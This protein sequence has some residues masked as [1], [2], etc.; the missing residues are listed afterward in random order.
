MVPKIIREVV[1]NDLC[2]GCGVCITVCPTNSISMAWNK[3]GLL[4]PIQNG[5]CE[6]EKKCIDV[7]P[8]NPTPKNILR[9]ENEI[10]SIFNENFTNEDSILG[11]YISIYSG[12]SSYFRSLSSSGGIATWVLKEI[13]LKKIADSVIVVGEDT[14]ENS[15]LFHYSKIDFPDELSQ[16]SQTKYYPITLSEVLLEI[17]KSEKKVA[18]IGIPCF[19]K[20]LRL[21]QYFYPSFG[22]KVVF[23]IGIFCGGMKSSF[24]T[25]Y[26][27][28]R[29]GVYKNEIVK[30]QYRIKDLSSTASDY[31][32]GVYNRYSKDF[33]SMKM[34]TVG[35]MWGTGMFKPNACEFCD[36]LSAELADIS[37]GDAWISPYAENGAGTNVI[38]VRTKAAEDLLL[39]GVENKEIILENLSKEQAVLSQRG[40]YNHR[41]I[42]LAHRIHLAE[43]KSKIIPPKR[44]SGNRNIDLAFRLVL[45]QRS[46]VREKSFIYWRESNRFEEFEKNM[47]FSLKWLKIFTFF[48]HLTRGQSLRIRLIRLFNSLAL[49]NK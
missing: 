31:S 47:K 17:E 5:K 9:T 32:F 12:Y 21:K 22:E 37:L 10:S 19:L 1:L 15:N 35:D 45:N 26:L 33:H 27:S 16:Y 23:T 25:E 30:P 48:Y 7:C 44:V 46:R 28:S 36:D 43:R 40:N 11:K 6:D 42:G 8:F 41:R 18:I 38:I 20:A 29:C 3:D 34:K 49:R 4:I 24:F 14:S 2:I 13:L 39:G